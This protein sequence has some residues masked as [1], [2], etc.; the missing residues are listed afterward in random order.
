MQDKIDFIKATVIGGVFFLIP[1]AVVVIVVGKL[2]IVM[3][4]VAKSLSPLIPVETAVGT[5]ILNLLAVLVI[6]A[7]CFL[8]GLA[9]QR[10]HA[11]KM[12]ARLESTL[13]AA[14]PGYAFIKAFADNM[15][16]SNEIAES[17]VPVGVHF[18]DYS[19]LAFEI[20]REPNGKVAVYLLSAPNPWSGTVVYVTPERVVRL[21]ITLKEAL[22]NIRVLGKGSAAILERRPNKGMSQDSD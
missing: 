12:V 3:K 17:F 6:L 8:A 16:R 18:D 9:A 11:K 21:S 1:L 19:Q 7:F 22:K 5:V 20:E 10:A 13:L 2:V 14:L 15:H 4:G